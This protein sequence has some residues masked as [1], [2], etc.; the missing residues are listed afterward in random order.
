MLTRHLGRSL[1]VPRIGNGNVV[2]LGGEHITALNSNTSVYISGGTFSGNGSSTTIGGAVFVSRGSAEIHNALIT[3]NVA[4]RGGGMYVGTSAIVNLNQ[5]IISGNTCTL[6]KDM[7]I[8]GATVNATSCFIDDTKLDGRGTL[9]LI[10]DCTIG[11]MYCMNPSLPERTGNVVIDSGASVNL[12]SSMIPGGNIIVKA[13]GCMINNTSFG[14]PSNDTV[15][16]S[17][18][19]SGGGASGTLAN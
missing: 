13:G 14:S 10:G 9:V 11:T 4:S 19:S 12:T 15:Y 17:I 1:T 16:T 3:E 5:V 6:G 18:V 7:H 8:V 2:Y